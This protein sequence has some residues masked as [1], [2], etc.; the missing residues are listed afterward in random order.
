MEEKKSAKSGVTAALSKKSGPF[1][2]DNFKKS[3]NLTEG[4]KFKK[5]EWLPLSPAFNNA[6]GLPGIPKG[7]ITVI[8]GHSDTGKTTAMIE[9]AI[10][11]QKDVILPVFVITEM[12]WSFE[13]AKEMGLE[14]EAVPDL[15]TGEVSYTGNFLYIDRSSL[16]VIEDVASFVIDIL[17]EQKK[18]N[19]PFD[20]L[21]LWDSAGSIP[22]QQ[23]VD[24]GKNNAMWNAAAMSTQFGNFI[25]QLFPLS[26]KANVQYTNTF[27][28]V[29]KVRVEYPVSN[30]MEKPKMRN[31]GG[32]VMYWDATL[33]ITFGNIT[34]SGVSKIEATK[35]KKTVVFAKRTKISVDKNHIT[36]S[37]TSARIVMTAHGF[38]ED[39]PNAIDKYKKDHRGEWLKILG[40]GDFDVIIEPDVP[41]DNKPRYENMV[42]EETSD[43]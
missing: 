17:T 32:D 20:L 12:K 24:S 15:E 29:N 28:V 8:R 23:S 42:D 2:L 31:K 39:T 18:G 37:T 40:E 1:N 21:F 9:A 27:L 7:H 4:I 36:E 10:A 35:D 43:E 33:V 3:K 6:I 30:P 19:L 26:R 22:S 34:N 14:V 16:N 13:H 38:I 11:A 25:N 41:E 5:Q